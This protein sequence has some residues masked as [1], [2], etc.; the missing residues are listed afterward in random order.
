MLLCWRKHAKTITAL[1]VNLNH[2]I[3]DLYAKLK[4]DTKY[5]REKQEMMQTL[6]HFMQTVRISMVDSDHGLRTFM[7]Q[8]Q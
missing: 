3:G 7:F 2:G 5:L 4:T 6:K 8:T 1:G